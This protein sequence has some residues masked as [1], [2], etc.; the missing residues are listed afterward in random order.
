M[1]VYDRRLADAASAGGIV[2]LSPGA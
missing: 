2:V 1:L